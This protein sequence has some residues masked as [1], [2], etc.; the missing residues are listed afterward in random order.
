V[1]T[2]LEMGG[3]QAAYGPYALGGVVAA[4]KLF[5]PSAGGF[6]RYLDT[7]TNTSTAPVT[8]NVRIEGSLGGVA[9]VIVDP[10]TTGNTYAVTL[11]DPTTISNSEDGPSTRPSLG[12][13]FGGPNAL[14]PVSAVHLQHLV[15][16]TYYQWTV[17]I[18]A[19][20][21]ATFMHFAL[22][23]YPMDLAGAQSQA[24]A[25]VNLTDPNALAGMTAEEKA[26]VVN[27][28]LQ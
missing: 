13:V 16:P 15:G 18:P 6:A 2:K 14:V 20:E 22:Q 5:V 23:R 7:L 27:F 24:Q 26:R 9:R 21:S 12:H 28:K 10:A 3:R 17:T 1:P 8:V 4:R 11:S 25:L 19:G